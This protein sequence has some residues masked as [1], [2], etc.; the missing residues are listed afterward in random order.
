[1]SQNQMA[2]SVFS[3]QKEIVLLHTEQGDFGI[4]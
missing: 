2:K 3:Y 4:S 1:M